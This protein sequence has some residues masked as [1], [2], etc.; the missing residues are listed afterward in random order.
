LVFF[1]NLR[2]S[3]ELA[4]I[5]PTVPEEVV[6]DEVIPTATFTLT[7]L[8]P[9]P[10]DTPTIAATNTKVV[11]EN[12]TVGNGD[13]NGTGDSGEAEATATPGPAAT[14]TPVPVA[15]PANGIEEVPETGFGGFEAGLIA[16][17]LIAV[18]AVSRRLR[19]AS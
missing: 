5:T 17:G 19:R 16:I 11:Q 7:P 2:Q 15:T 9:T 10:T 18:L 4:Q 8:P 14:D 3:Q 6:I 12:G 1:R 13:Q